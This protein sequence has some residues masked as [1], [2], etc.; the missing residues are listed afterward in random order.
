MIKNMDLESFSG[1]TVGFIR[2][3]G[4]MAD[5]MVEVYIEGAIIKRE[6]VNGKMEER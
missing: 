4:R 5:N 2:D 3:I 1:Q 6:K